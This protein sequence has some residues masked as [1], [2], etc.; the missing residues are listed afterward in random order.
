MKRGRV[1]KGREGERREAMED[2]EQESDEYNVQRRDHRSSHDVPACYS[3]KV[4]LSAAH[5]ITQ[6]STA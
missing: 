4:K 2:T 6:P 5:A 1:G 3:A